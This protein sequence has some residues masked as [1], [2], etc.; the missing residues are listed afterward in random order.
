[1]EIIDNILTKDA[2]LDYQEVMNELRGYEA[3][4]DRLSRLVQ[5]GQVV[6]VKQGLYLSPG[7]K[8]DPLVLSALVYGPSYVSL[9]TAMAIHGMIPERTEEITAITSKRAK[10]FATPVGRFRYHPVNERVFPCG[11]QIVE[12]DGGSYLLAEPEKALCDRVARVR[13]LSA[14]RDV[15]PLLAE[16]LRIDMDTLATL[17]LPLMKEITERYRRK[18]VTAF[19]RWLNRWREKRGRPS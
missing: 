16:D 19:Y 6:R 9:E 7:A 3:P 5:Q 14:Q 1:V 18:N 10:L 15:E 13:G 17:R 2:P 12:A 4:R 11:F 8:V